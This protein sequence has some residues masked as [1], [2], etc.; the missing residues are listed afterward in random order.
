MSARNGLRTLIRAPTVE[1]LSAGDLIAAGYPTG[2]AEVTET[3][4]QKLSTVDACMEILSNSIAKLPAYVMQSQTR[5]RVS[6]PILELLNVRPNEA[7]TPFIRKKVL[8]NSVNEGGQRLRLDCPGPPDPAAGGADP[9]ALAAGPALAGHVGP[10]VVHREP[11]GDRGPHDF[12][13][14]GYLPL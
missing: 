14:R 3:T 13:Q 4:A 2:G 9:R 7:M 10:G 8:E 6:H 5:E 1:N 12:A 11:P